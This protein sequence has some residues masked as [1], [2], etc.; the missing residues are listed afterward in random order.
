ME[1]IQPT[2]TPYLLVEPIQVVDV[3][4]SKEDHEGELEELHPEPDVEIHDIPEIDKEPII[5]LD[6]PEEFI[7]V[8]KVESIEE[9]GPGWL[10]ESD[11]SSGEDDH[12]ELTPTVQPPQLI[13]ETD[14]S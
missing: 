10:I 2:P 5:D 4:S 1:W 6:S 3:L 9:N 11:D 8:L 13:V 12:P 14:S 7:P